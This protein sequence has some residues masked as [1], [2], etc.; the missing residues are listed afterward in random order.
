M[1]SRPTCS[2]C[3]ASDDLHVV[4][5]RYSADEP[6][7]RLL[8]YCSRCGEE[9]NPATSLPI[10]LCTPEVFVDYYRRGLTNSAPDI[11]AALVFGEGAPTG[12]VETALRLMQTREEAE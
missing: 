11:A 4:T 12:I 3:G 7:G 5:M 9:M 8:V 10:A 6:G 1:S 2:R